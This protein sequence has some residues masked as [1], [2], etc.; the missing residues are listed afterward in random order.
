MSSLSS[1]PARAVLSICAL[2]LV[3]IALEKSFHGLTW[4]HLRAD[5][6]ALSWEAAGTQDG[7][8]GPVPP[9]GR[10]VHYR[11]ATFCRVVDGR[12]VELASVND[13]FG[14]LQQLGVEIAPPPE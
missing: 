13:L 3:T 12:V 6:H 2:I 9:T 8:F 14:L 11:G 7:P 1:G 10:E 5:I 4:A